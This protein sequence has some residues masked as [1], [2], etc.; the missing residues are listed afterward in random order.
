MWTLFSD[1]II[2][3]CGNRG[4]QILLLTSSFVTLFSENVVYVISVLLVSNLPL[5]GFF[6]HG[7]S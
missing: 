3:V 2:K 7:I 6:L 1:L 5:S 4:S